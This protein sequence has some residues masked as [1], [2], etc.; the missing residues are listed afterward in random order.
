MKV[1]W[2]VADIAIFILS[3]IRLKTSVQQAAGELP[4]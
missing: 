4:E 1:E 3:Q 2:D